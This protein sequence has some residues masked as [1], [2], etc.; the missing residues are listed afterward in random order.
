MS[1]PET[2]GWVGISRR[3]GD[4]EASADGLRGRAGDDVREGHLLPELEMHDRA[5]LRGQVSQS[6]R[7]VQQEGEERGRV[8]IV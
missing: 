5:L 1:A 3:R 2:L 4:G 7:E 6:S 8:L